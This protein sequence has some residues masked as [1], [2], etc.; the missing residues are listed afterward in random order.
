MYCMDNYDITGLDPQSAKEYV[1]AAVTT[2][3][4]TQE[5]RAELEREAELWAKRIELA[6]EHG[7]EELLSQAM[8]RF[9]QVKE[10]LNRIKAEE[11]ELSGGVIRLKSQ[12][13]LILNQPELDMDAD[14]LAAQLE[15]MEDDLK[16]D[17]LADKFREE[18]AEDALAKLKAQMDEEKEG[19]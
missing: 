7:K 5:K 12:L 17:E 11:A 6:K 8:E 18:E 9:S 14:L 1:F 13:K 3:K 2:L 16:K 4:A 19:G 15:L 10:D